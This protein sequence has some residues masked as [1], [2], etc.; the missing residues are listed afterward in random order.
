ML[1]INE[2]SGL[3]MFQEFMSECKV[4]LND[5]YD[6]FV[7]YN[8]KN[9]ERDNKDNPTFMEFCLM[10]FINYSFKLFKDVMNESIPKDVKMVMDMMEGK[11]KELPN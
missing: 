1:E 6:S 11:T 8:E 4:E 3:D 5:N 7:L 9:K 10:E 2:G